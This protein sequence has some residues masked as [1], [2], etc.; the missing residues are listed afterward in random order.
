MVVYI[1]SDTSWQTTQNNC[2]TDVRPPLGF[3]GAE[4]SM[5]LS[6]YPLVNTDVLVLQSTFYRRS[7]LYAQVQL[8]DQNVDFYCGF[9]TT[10][11][12]ASALPYVGNYGKGSM[13]S[14]TAYENEQVF[15]AQQVVNYVQKKSGSN[16]AIVVGDWRSSVA[17]SADAGVVGPP[18]TF[19]P[20]VLNDQTM[21]LFQSTPAWTF[22]V[23]TTPGTT[24]GPQCNFCP[25]AENPYNLTDSYF[26][27]QP[28]ISNWPGAANATTSESLIYTQGAVTLDAGVQAPVSPYYGINFRVIRPH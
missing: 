26:V 5:I 14:Q 16:P 10:T 8:E 22:V 1:A 19:L 15:Q 7:V 11:L 6:R 17:V 20:N 27:A 13:D 24:W 21:M 12:N 9:L 4:N 25:Q 18:G 23:D 3:A 2:T 28:I